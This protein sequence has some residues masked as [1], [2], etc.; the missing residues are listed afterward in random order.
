MNTTL[1]V[2]SYI[3]TLALGWVIGWTDEAD[4]WFAIVLGLLVLS[5]HVGNIRRA[6]DG[7]RQ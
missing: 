1:I 4:M 5:R 3:A 6:I 7:L 2:A